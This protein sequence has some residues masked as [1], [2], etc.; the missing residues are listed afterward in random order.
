MHFQCVCLL[1]AWGTLNLAI[2]YFSMVWK[3]DIL[4]LYVNNIS[5]FENYFT[6]LPLLHFFTI[7]QEK[8]QTE[9]RTVAIDDVSTVNFATIDLNLRRKPTKRCSLFKKVSAYR[10]LKGQGNRVLNTGIKSNE[11]CM[12]RRVLVFFR[13]WLVFSI[14]SVIFSHDYSL[15]EQVRVASFEFVIHLLNFWDF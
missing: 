7:N 13:P 4:F 11:Y 1:H 14:Y 3:T 10:D 15:V 2:V 8:R 5:D 9:T 6:F 12:F